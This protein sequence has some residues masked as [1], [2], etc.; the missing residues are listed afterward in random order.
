MFF[1]LQN[2]SYETYLSPAGAKRPA[3]IYTSLFIRNTD[4]KKTKKK[5]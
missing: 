5:R 3:F 4:S 1:V 2:F